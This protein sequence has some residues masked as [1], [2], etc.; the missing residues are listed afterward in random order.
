[1]LL[2]P[3]NINANNLSREDNLSL[4]AFGAAHA[5]CWCVLGSA[6]G[7]ASSSTSASPTTQHSHV[8]TT[9][10]DF[11]W[12]NEFEPDATAGLRAQHELRLIISGYRWEA[13]SNMGTF[14]Q[15]ARDLDEKD[16][17][18]FALLDSLTRWLLPTGKA[19]PCTSAPTTSA[20]YAASGAEIMVPT[21]ACGTRANLVEQLSAAAGSSMGALGTRE[22]IGVGGYWSQGTAQP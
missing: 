10:L 17:A 18:A 16:I 13:H 7:Q 15:E 20:C 9:Q 5:Q 21:R 19:V 2:V 8:D 3:T 6:H 22:V 11:P 12:Q 4:Q 14:Q 1:M